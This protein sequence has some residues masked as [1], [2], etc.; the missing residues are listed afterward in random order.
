MTRTVNLYWREH[1]FRWCGIEAVLLIN[2][3]AVVAVVKMMVSNTADLCLIPP[4]IC[5]IDGIKGQ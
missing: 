3:R 1:T 2:T 5:V 4:E